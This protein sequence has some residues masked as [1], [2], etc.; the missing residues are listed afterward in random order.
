MKIKVYASLSSE[1][2]F[3]KGKEAGLAEG[4]A[5]YFSYCNE[6]ELELDVH[7]ESGAVYGAKVTQ[8]F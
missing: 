6:I 2:L 8:K 1:S 7:P 3:E 5:D 4:A